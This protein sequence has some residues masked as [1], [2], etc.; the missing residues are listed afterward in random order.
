ME[1]YIL[2]LYIKGDNCN[3]MRYLTL[4]QFMSELTYD[5]PEG[6]TEMRLG[7]GP[8]LVTW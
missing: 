1:E 8:T 3:W 2:H 7:E 4:K 6:D 5:F